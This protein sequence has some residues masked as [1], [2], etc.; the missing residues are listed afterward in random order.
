VGIRTRKAYQNGDRT[1][2]QELVKEYAQLARLLE[3]FYLAHKKRWLAENKPFGFEVQ[4]VRIGGLK[5]RLVHCR[6]RLQSYLD[7]EIST[8]EELEEQILPEFDPNIRHNHWGS[9]VTPGSLTIA[10]VGR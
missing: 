6:E 10:Y 7:G 4:D 1:G 5:Q 8:I 3:E 9:Q 2:L